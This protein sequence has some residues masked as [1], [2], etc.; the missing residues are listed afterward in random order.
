[1]EMDKPTWFNKRDLLTFGVFAVFST[2]ISVIAWLVEFQAG[3]KEIGIRVAFHCLSIFAIALYAYVL[4]FRHHKLTRFTWLPRHG[5]FLDPGGFDIH[6]PDIDNVMERVINGWEKEANWPARQVMANN[7]VYIS[8]RPLPL[9]TPNGKNVLGYPVP[10]AFEV[11]VGMNKDDDVNETSLEHELNH[12]FYGH[13][14]KKWNE[15]EH[16][17]YFLD[18]GFK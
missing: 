17:Q 11:I 7:P 12:M 14:V 10:R 15:E 16:H 1:M 2:A 4:Y 13:F 3:G 6:H 18:F 9:Y 5:I 8:F